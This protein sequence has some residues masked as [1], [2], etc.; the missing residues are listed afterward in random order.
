LIPRENG[1]RGLSSSQCI[2]SIR[3]T[4][5]VD[6]V[7]DDNTDAQPVDGEGAQLVVRVYSKFIF[8]WDRERG[9]YEQV[10]V[11]ACLAQGIE[12]RT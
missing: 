7:L 10:G 8:K 5:D 2:G 3:N 1:R 6:L 4:V 12:R 11:V 9:T